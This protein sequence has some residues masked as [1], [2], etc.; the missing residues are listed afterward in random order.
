M[1]VSSTGHCPTSSTLLRAL[2]ADCYG[3]TAGSLAFQLLLGLT[4]GRRYSPRWLCLCLQLGFSTEGH[5]AC[6]VAPPRVQ[7]LLGEE[8]ASP[9][10]WF[11]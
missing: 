8:G 3:C 5:S 4:Y 2:E 1:G 9:S 10:L 7:F 6:L 11:P